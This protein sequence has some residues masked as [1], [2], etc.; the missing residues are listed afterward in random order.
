M[1]IKG[2]KAMPLSESA[3]K[4]GM[5]DFDTM[6]DMVLKIIVNANVGITNTS[7]GSVVRTLVESLVQNDASSNYFIERVYDAI[8]IDTARGSDL[9]A[10]V[11]ILGVVRDMPTYARGSVTMTT[12]IEPAKYDIAIP[13]HTIIT[14]RKD[15]N[16]KIYEFM[17]D[18]KNAVLPS[19]ASSVTVEVVAVDA[20]HQYIPA[21]GLTVLASSISG[22][23]SV[24]NED[25]IDSG[26]DKESDDDL[27]QRAKNISKS[28]GKCTISAIELAVKDID[29]VTDCNV[30]DMPDGN[31]A[32][33]DVNVATEVIPPLETVKN[34][35]DA[36][37]LATKGAGIYTNINYPSVYQGDGIS[38]S[39]N[40]MDNMGGT[41]NI[42]DDNINIIR[43]AISSYTMTLGIG[44]PFIIRQMER[45]ILDALEDEELDISTIEPT[46]NIIPGSME[47]VRVKEF[48]IN[49][50]RYDG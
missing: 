25:A 45:Y 32:T 26:K 14:T 6:V 29:G 7:P 35:V 9:D 46:S 15:N 1:G 2:G 13:Y 43:S 36:V 4:L 3:Q 5:K 34:D 39:I 38:V 33:I 41:Y 30:V 16:G 21:G 11:A 37:V 23:Q 50:V 44:E 24:Y 12:G 22:I 42:T 28:Y 8:N 47:I 18:D 19:G 20:G 17:V 40:I 10:L 27:R 49:G 31:I 48:T